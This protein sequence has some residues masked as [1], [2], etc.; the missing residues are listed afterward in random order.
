MKTISIPCPLG[1]PSQVTSQ[2]P[3]LFDQCT[4]SLNP[5]LTAR[6]NINTVSATV[7]NAL[8]A[9]YPNTIATSDVQSILNNQPT[10]TGG[11]T[12][13]PIYATPTWLVTKANLSAAT[14]KTLEPIITARSFVYRFQVIGYYDG[15]G[16]TSRVEAIV[17]T[18]NGRPRLVYQ[19]DLNALGKGFDPTQ[20][21]SD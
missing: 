13:D 7:L 12:P 6:I 3:I 11:E 20:L 9:A 17:D 18:S 10:Y 8:S 4:T 2:M 21:N 19:R 15:G 16:P 5:D 1:D 14:L